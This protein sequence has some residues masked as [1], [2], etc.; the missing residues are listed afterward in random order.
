MDHP[1]SIHQP[2]ALKEIELWM[3]LGYQVL[4]P[5][6]FCRVGGVQQFPFGPRPL[7]R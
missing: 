5:P 1:R 6:A 4:P 7:H 2:A 3:T